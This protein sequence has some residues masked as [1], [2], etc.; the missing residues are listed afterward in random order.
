MEA[1]Q[2]IT[3]SIAREHAGKVFL[4]LKK[5]SDI[6]TMVYCEIKLK[7]TVSV[8]KSGLKFIKVRDKNTKRLLKYYLTELHVGHCL[9]HPTGVSVKP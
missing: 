2:K 9:W 3:N 1:I 5:A 4:N 8:Y 7:G 6:I